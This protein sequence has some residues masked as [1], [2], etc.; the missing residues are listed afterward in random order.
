MDRIKLVQLADSLTYL[1]TMDL[2]DDSFFSIENYVET[3]TYDS[4]T[5]FIINAFALHNNNETAIR[6]L[7]AGFKLIVDS[8]WESYNNAGVALWR[9]Y[10][11]QVLVSYCGTKSIYDDCTNVHLVPSYFWIREFLFSKKNKLDRYVPSRINTKKFLMPMNKMKPDRR[12]IYNTLKDDDAIISRHEDGISLPMDDTGANLIF[13][14]TTDFDREFNSNWYDQ[15]YFSV[16]TETNQTVL[17]EE[18]KGVIP[19]GDTTETMKRW[20]GGSSIFITEK[21][22]KPIMFSHPFIV[23]GQSGTLARLSELGFITFRHI[24]D[25]SYDKEFGARNRLTMIK[26]DIENF[27]VMLYDHP[28]T[29]EILAYNRNHFYNEEI[30]NKML[31]DE[32]I[33]PLMEFANA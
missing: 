26:N 20:Y 5:V 8:V 11:N 6:I 4:Q 13:T 10:G 32:I 33:E 29:A 7:D 12:I 18:L 22:F 17:P 3:K 25:E 16:V 21:T 15:T 23:M 1:S 24:F 2:L 19:P 28:L 31:Q 9:K 27:D 14:S 30:V